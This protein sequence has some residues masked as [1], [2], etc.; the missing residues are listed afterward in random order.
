MGWHF[1]PTNKQI[2]AC[3]LSTIIN[4]SHVKLFHFIVPFITSPSK[5]KDK[6]HDKDNNNG[7]PAKNFLD[8]LCHFTSFTK[9]GHLLKRCYELDQLMFAWPSFQQWGYKIR[10]LIV[11]SKKKHENHII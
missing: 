1:E 7:C 3:S 8:D 11:N 2:I 9:E 5:Y 6:R 4:Q 10:S